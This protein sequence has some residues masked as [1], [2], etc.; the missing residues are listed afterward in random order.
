M[1]VL[2]RDCPASGWRLCPLLDRFPPT[3]DDFLWMPDSPLYLAGGPKAVAQEA[4]A[5]I[6]AAVAADAGGIARAALANTLEQLS[7]FASGDGLQAWP[8]Q[9]TP[10]I[11]RDF[12][13]TERSAYASAL[14]QRGLLTVSPVLARMHRIT[15]LAGIAACIL[16]LPV[17]MRRR[18]ACLGF[19]LA[20]LIV[21]P[22]SAVITGWLSG[23]HDRYQARIMWLPPLIATVSVLSLRRPS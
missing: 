8:D 14:Q 13:Q 5:I 16:L 4:R 1:T 19:L 15:A 17:A 12:P 18:A 23:P 21:L 6:A 9:V 11:E 10:W 3:S 22:V 20:A 7:S 2:Q